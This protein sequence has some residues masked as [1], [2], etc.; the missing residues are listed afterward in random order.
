MVR[1]LLYMSIEGFWP[2]AKGELLKYHG[3]FKELFLYYLKE[4]ELKYNYRDEDLFDKIIKV[5]KG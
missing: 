3:M 5:I 2:Y 1:N 4:L